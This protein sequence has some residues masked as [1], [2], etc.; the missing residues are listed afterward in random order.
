MKT[1]PIACFLLEDLRRAR[2]TLRRYAGSKCP[3]GKLGYHNAHSD[4]IAETDEK[5]GN[6]Y[7]GSNPPEVAV[8]DPRWPAACACGY[9][10]T[11]EDSRQVFAHGLYRRAD[12]GEVLTWEDAPAGAIREASWWPDKGADGKGWC[13]RL[14]DG[15]DWMT[16]GGAANCSCRKTA[17]VADHRCW[18][19]TGVAPR[20]TVTPSI[21]TPRWHGFLRDGRLLTV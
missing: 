1:D 8:D 3:A 18:T 14:P 7:T 13:V 17:T 21:A 15:S 10:F 4:V 12:T 11:F 19:R 16:E 20:L 9:A 5:P 2:Y 6:E